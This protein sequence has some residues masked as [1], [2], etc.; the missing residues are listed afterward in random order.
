MLE[1]AHKKL[2]VWKLGKELIADI[3]ALTESFPKSEIFGLTNQLRRA[4]VSI[5]S[6]ISEGAS[7]SSSVERK[8]FFTIARSS[9]VEIDTQ[10]EIALSLDFLT[11]RDLEKIDTKVNTLFAMLTNLIKKTA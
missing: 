8:R 4:S 9:L 11:E 6:N 2:D 7:R 5:V 3:Y 10:I 1:F